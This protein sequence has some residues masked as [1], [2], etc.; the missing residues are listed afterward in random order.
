MLGTFVIYLKELKTSAK[1]F[2]SPQMALLPEQKQ[3]ALFAHLSFSE[4]E[5]LQV[6]SHQ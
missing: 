2:G 6:G 5:K 1:S 4:S 3:V